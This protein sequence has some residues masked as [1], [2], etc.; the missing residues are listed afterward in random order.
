MFLRT[1][2]FKCLVILAMC[3]PCAS[4]I[5]AEEGIVPSDA[6]VKVVPG[7]NGGI[8]FNGIFHIT[9]SDEARDVLERGIP[10]N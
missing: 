9:L 5:A 7:K 3:L 10:L 8:F 6:I 1:L 2:A 4:L